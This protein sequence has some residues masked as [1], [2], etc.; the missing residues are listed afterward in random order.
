M[1]PVERVLCDGC[2]NRITVPGRAWEYEG[3]IL[4]HIVQVHPNA[5]CAKAAERRLGVSLR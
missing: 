2:G 1:K 3:K 5:R 4:G